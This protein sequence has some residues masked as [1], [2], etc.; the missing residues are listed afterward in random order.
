[1][2]YSKKFE[3]AQGYETYIDSSLFVTPNLDTIGANS[4]AY[5]RTPVT[6]L[7]CVYDVSNISINTNMKH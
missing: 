4:A 2:K 3:D 5:H 1:M 7:K 6:L